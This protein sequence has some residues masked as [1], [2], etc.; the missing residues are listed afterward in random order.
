MRSIVVNQRQAPRVTVATVYI[1]NQRKAN[2]HDT[3]GH[4]VY[5]LTLYSPRMLHAS[6]ET[7][8]NTNIGMSFQILLKQ[9]QTKTCKHNTR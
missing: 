5:H 7:A 3:G 6:C 8:S 4:E 9:Q 1:N 2:S